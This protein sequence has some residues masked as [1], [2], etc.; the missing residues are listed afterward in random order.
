MPHERLI[1][2]VLTGPGVFFSNDERDQVRVWLESQTETNSMKTFVP[3]PSVQRPI[4]KKGPDNE[5]HNEP[6]KL[7]LIRKLDH[8]S[9]KQ[10][11]LTYDAIKYNCRTF[12]WNAE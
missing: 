3:H 6:V 2:N 8:G 11:F 7:I 12:E 9:Q 1:R 10:E 4:T 5:D